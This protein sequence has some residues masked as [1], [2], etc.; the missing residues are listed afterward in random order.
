MIILLCKIPT[1]PHFCVC[2][3]VFVCVHASTCISSLPEQMNA[4]CNDFTEKKSH[5]GCKR[6]QHYC[7]FYVV[8][9]FFKS[10]VQSGDE[11]F[12]SKK[13]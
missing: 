6:Q 8:I 10:L 3:C 4:A 12:A 9:D 5:N 11:S 2:V 7:I 1:Q 13:C